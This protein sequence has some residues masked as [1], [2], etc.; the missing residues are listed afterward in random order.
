MHKVLLVGA[1]TTRRKHFIWRVYLKKDIIY[2]EMHR[3]EIH[4]DVGKR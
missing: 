4:E 1:T 3:H 2:C